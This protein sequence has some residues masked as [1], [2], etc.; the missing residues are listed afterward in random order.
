M[1]KVVLGLASAAALL[2][3]LSS[4]AR[5]GDSDGW[6]LA[7][8]ADYLSVGNSRKHADA[9][10]HRVCE[11]P[12]AAGALS[13]A[14]T[15][16]ASGAFG[17][18]VG[19]LYHT[20]AFYVGPTVGVLSGGPTAGEVSATTVPPG[21]TDRKRTEVTGRALVEFGART[22]LSDS[23]VAGVGAGL[24]MALVSESAVCSDAGALRGTCAASGFPF[25]AKRGWA[26]WEL[27]PFVEYRSLDF[28]FRFVGFGRGSYTPW[29]A[30]GVFLGGRF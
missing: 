6:R 4:P 8:A 5:A 18:R 25:T 28:G 17:G 27:G 16:K 23:W 22:A 30:L 2:V 7:V 12:L 1:D 26:T 15:A 10:A 11:A 3:G 19:G 24:G 13:C 20:G 14:G 21:S 9:A 29:T